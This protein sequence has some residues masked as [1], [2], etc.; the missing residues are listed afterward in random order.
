MRF[1]GYVQGTLLWVS[2]SDKGPCQMKNISDFEDIFKK[3]LG[4][5]LNLKLDYSLNIHHLKCTTIQLLNDKRD[6]LLKLLTAY[7]MGETISTLVFRPPPPTQLRS[8]FY[9]WLEIG[10][11]DGN[12]I[13][14][15]YIQRPRS[16]VTL[17]FSHGNAEDLGM[18]F[19]RMKALSK[20]LGVNIMAYEYTG[21]G[22][23]TGKIGTFQNTFF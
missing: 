12:Q 20:M 11:E 4:G 6:I 3:I 22:I 2:F 18:M 21:Y 10:D 19:P 23:S 8:S 15:F 14:A 17:L 13:P 9:F 7:N 5:W 16:K 1:F